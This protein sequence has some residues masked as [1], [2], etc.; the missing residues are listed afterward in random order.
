MSLEMFSKENPAVAS[1]LPDTYIEFAPI[2][3]EIWQNHTQRTIALDADFLYTLDDYLRN[4][5]PENYRDILYQ[6]GEQ[7]GKNAY[8][9][10]ESLI[11]TV[12]PD[13]HAISE[14][15]MNQFHAVFTSHLAA[16]G[17]GHFELKRRDELLFVDLYHS[18]YVDV[19][20]SNA[21]GSGSTTGTVCHLYSG[22]FSGIFS[23]LS[24]MELACMEITCRSEG[25]EHCSFLLDNI[26]TINQ[27]YRYMASGIKPL[28]AYERLKKDIEQLL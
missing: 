20:R 19:L 9:Y 2:T 22:F 15:S 27:L 1:V 25:Y 21:T 26:D 4:K 23:R 5:D 3:A 8:G 28:E 16:M 7:W 11:H 18:L 13:C 17:W 10:I 12:Y 24:N 6:I 14:L